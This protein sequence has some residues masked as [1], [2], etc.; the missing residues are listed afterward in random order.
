[1]YVQFNQATD[2]AFRV[3]IHLAE[4]PEGELANSQAIAEEQN[5]PIGF[6]QKIMRSLVKGELVKS[7]RGVDG[8]FVL[9][10][11]AEKISLLDVIEVMEGPLDLQRCL[12]EESACTK[13]CNAKCPV[14]TSLAVIQANFT[15]A[16]SEV[17][18]A[19]LVGKYKEER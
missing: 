15:K 9:A 3:I 5:I 19:G 11:S 14:H 2:Y 16:L 18:F 12:K 1:M 17:N 13:G 7:Y 8:G 4:L 6:L 10:T